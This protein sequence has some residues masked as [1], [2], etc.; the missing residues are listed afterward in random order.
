MRRHRIGAA[1]VLALALLATVAVAG[2]TAGA[3]R[4]IREARR[5]ALRDVYRRLVAARVP[6]GARPVKAV[7]RGLHLNS[8]GSIPA[9]P[10]VVQMHS[11]FLSPRPREAVIAWIKA[12]PPV[13]T[14][15][16][17][18]GSFGIGKKTVVKYLGFESPEVPGKLSERRTLFAV[19]ARPGG[20]SAIRVDT[21]AVWITPRPAA[22]AIPAGTRL[23]DV[24]VFKQGKVRRSKVIAA[25]HAVRSIVGLIDGFEATQ[26]GTVSCPDLGPVEEEL[27]LEFRH[28]R[29]GPVLAT[30]EAEVPTGCGRPL[31]LKIHGRKTEYL[32]GGWLLL[33]R[34]RPLLAGAKEG[35]G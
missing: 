24:K 23:I 3:P 16:Q 13:T 5:T 1:A 33:K 32:E 2:S 30:A 34:L 31:K 22:G 19:A 27:E 26:P 12:H 20:G 6:P 14:G 28:R 11:Y 15:M 35:G 21:Q 4:P 9:T 10:N 25:P 29:G 8:G 17:E 7:G 18:S